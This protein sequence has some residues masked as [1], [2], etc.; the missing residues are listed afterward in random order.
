MNYAEAAAWL[1]AFSNLEQRLDPRQWAGIKLERVERLVALLGHPERH[2]RSVH[3]AGSKG[4]GSTAAM[5]ASILRAAGW[6]VGLYTSP[7]LVSARERIRLDGVPISEAA[8]AQLITARLRPAAERYHAAPVEGPLTYFDLHTVLAFLAFQEAGVDWSVIEVGLGGRLD[9]TNVVLPEVSI[10]SALGLEHTALLGH[11]LAEIAGEK[12]G[13]IKPGVPVVTAPQEPEAAAVLAAVAAARGAPLIQ[14]GGVVADGPPV[15]D[16]E[17]PWGQ[18][19]R[20]AGAD[21]GGRVRLPLLGLHQVENACLAVTAA[22][23]L[24]DGAGQ[25]RPTPAQVRAGLAAVRWPGRLEP[26]ERRPWLVLDGAHTPASARR[27]AEA[28]ELFPHQ[29]RYLILGSAMDKD[30]AGLAAAL[31]NRADGVLVTD[32]PDNRRAAAGARLLPVVAP[33]CR[34][35]AATASPAEALA[36]ARSWAGPDD[37]ICGA[38]SLYLVGALYRELRGEEPE[39]W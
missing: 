4:K 14:A 21:G 12:A 3:L 7:H 26:I 5:T 30:F 15:L 13:I 2:G 16:G 29:R 17:P 23:L 39:A 27:L 31:C 1:D 37:L 10:I 24:A 38:G 8:V 22:G 6:R 36:L 32:I 20:V 11:T 25:G 34:R 9:A 19:V 35:V 33:H 28:L 18:P